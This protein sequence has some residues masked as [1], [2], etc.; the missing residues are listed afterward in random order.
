MSLISKKLD[1]ELRQVVKLV[2]QM[3]TNLWPGEGTNRQLR[4]SLIDI[5]IKDD[6]SAVSV[7]DKVSNKLLVS[8]LKERFPKDGI[9]AE[10]SWPHLTRGSS[11]RIWIL[12]P[13]DGTNSFLAGK[14]G[15]AIMLGLSIAGRVELGYVYLPCRQVQFVGEVGKGA[16]IDGRR[17]KVSTNGQLKQ[18][19]VCMRHCSPKLSRQF[20]PIYRDTHLAMLDVAAGKLDGMILGIK[21]HKEWDIAGPTAIIKAAGGTVTNEHGREIKFGGQPLGFKYF[22]ASNGRVHNELLKLMP[23]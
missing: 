21:R 8:A 4:R 14:T 6:G 7:V 12:D 15:F 3:Q 5:E 16:F 23:R 11:K 1:F 20:T 17:I 22:V 2:G 10:E 18:G 9:Y 13:L 19:R